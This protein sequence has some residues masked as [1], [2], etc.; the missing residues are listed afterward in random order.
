MTRRVKGTIHWVA[1]PTAKQVECRLYEN[2]VDEEKGKLNEDG[3]LNLNPNSLT[4]LK[5]CYVE[6][7]LAEAKAYDSFQFMRNGYFCA[8]CKDSRPGSPVFNRIVSLKSFRNRTQQYRRLKNEALNARNSMR[9]VCLGKGGNRRIFAKKVEGGG[10]L[11]HGT[12]DSAGY[13]RKAAS[14]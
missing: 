8:D 14:V 4:I 5:N 2:I 11:R 10:V 3:S 9:R 6:S 12:D 7:Q 1:V 13:R